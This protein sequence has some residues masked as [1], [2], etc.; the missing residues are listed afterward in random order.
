MH[1]SPRRWTSWLLRIRIGEDRYRSRSATAMQQCM[2]MPCRARG[3]SETD[4]GKR[5]DRHRKSDT[6][7]AVGRGQQKIAARVSSP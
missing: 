5:D 3:D 7:P 2:S 6:V 4:L 1:G